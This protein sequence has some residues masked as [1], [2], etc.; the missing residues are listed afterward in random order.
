MIVT[1]LTPTFNRGGESLNNLYQS[2]QKQTVKD[3]EWLLVDDGSIDDTKNIAEEMRKKP[4][5]R[6]G[7]Y[8]K[9][10]V[11]STRH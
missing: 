3:F 8:T 7:T 6:C 5:F 11:A 2:L 10:T 1:V 4:N 9:K